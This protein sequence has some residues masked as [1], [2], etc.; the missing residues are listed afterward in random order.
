[1]ANELTYTTL[2]NQIAPRATYPSYDANIQAR[3]TTWMLV[4]TLLGQSALWG[5]TPT[6][7]WTVDSSCDGVTAGTAGD[8]VDYW[9]NSGTFDDTLMPSVNASN[10]GPFA[11]FV[12]KSP[13]NLGGTGVFNY[14]TISLD[15]PVSSTNY[16]GPI[17]SFS[18]TQPTGGSTTVRP[19]AAD[20]YFMTDV[21]GGNTFYV[22]DRSIVQDHYT[23]TVL[24]TRGDFYFWTSFTGSGNMFSSVFHTLLQDTKSVDLNKTVSYAWGVPAQTV[25]HVSCFVFN[26]NLG[27]TSIFKTG[28]GQYGYWQSSRLRCRNY[29]GT[30][31]VIATLGAMGDPV[32]AS[33]MQTSNAPLYA[34]NESD[35]SFNEWY[36]PVFSTYE[37][38][39][40]FAATA[41][42]TKPHRE[43]KGRIADV[44]NVSG[45][46]LQCAV[47][48]ASAPYEYIKL[49]DLWFPW[50]ASTGPEI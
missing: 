31:T 14:M 33:A 6:G 34:S 46:L 42:P 25:N 38:T 48:P 45:A 9:W 13:A 35:G 32:N 8:M 47:R 50:T 19:S 7:V 41:D 11:W 4:E 21:T 24:S 39:S 20:N 10:T 1:M 40:T 3:W 30:A 43:L 18:K 15:A 44:K 5:S 28:N 12:L 2:E 26:G 49:G 23:H 22:A 16:F 17:I 37:P 29:D 36:C 27:D